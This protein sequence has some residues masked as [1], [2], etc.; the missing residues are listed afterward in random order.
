MVAVRTRSLIALTV[1]ALAAAC[2]GS[3]ARVSPP[4]VLPAGP[5]TIPDRIPDST[6][7]RMIEEFSEPSGYFSSDNFVSNEGELQ[8]VLAELAPRTPKGGVYVGVGPEQNFTYIAA[9]QPRIAFIC[10]IRRQNLLEHLMYKALFELSSDRAD[11]LSR[12]WSRER[13]AGLTV[14]S[15]ADTMAARF[16]NVPSDSVRYARNIAAIFDVLVNRHGFALT[17]DDSA[18]LRYVYSAFYVFGPSVSYTSRPNV[19]GPTFGALQ[20]AGSTFPMLS[21]NDSLQRVAD[22]LARMGMPVRVTVDSA[23][24]AVTT[25]TM[26]A[27]LSITRGAAGLMPTFANL[28]V[29]DDGTGAQRGWLANEQNFRM[30]KDFEARNL[31]VPVVGDFG[32]P[33]ALR[34]IATYLRER[35]ANVNLFYV[36]N[37]EQYLFPGD[38]WHRFYKNV[39]TFPYDSN[40]SFI[41]S[42][43]NSRAVPVRNPRSRMAQMTSSITHV[44]AA[45]EAGM[46]TS[47]A[48]VIEMRR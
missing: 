19:P 44:I 33:K 32:G 35:R 38:S 36:S 16:A 39:A 46:L 5:P 29:E 28:M 18:S 43:S 45:Y 6:Y 13:P 22:S 47:Y 23:G 40:S 27:M 9:F 8:Y 25:V 1:V 2:A 17:S 21:L 26:G 48:Q 11:F 4:R 14:L 31:L 20:R 41:R 37:V 12:L 24:R 3:P 42:A 7:W 15:S 34:A 30:L 10:D